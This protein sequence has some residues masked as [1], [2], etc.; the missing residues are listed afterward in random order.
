MTDLRPASRHWL[1]ASL[2]AAL[3]AGPVMG[4]ASAAPCPI[5]LP[6]AGEFS[7]GFGHRGGRL[8]PGVD[9]RAPVGSEVRAAAGGMVIFAG[10]YF[11]YG[12]MLEIEHRDGSV[13]R[14]AHL[15]RI[16]PDI[17]PGAVVLPGE[18]VA[19]LGRTGRTTGPHLH[20][21]LRRHGRAV[22]PWPWLTRTACLADTEVAEAPR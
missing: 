4:S 3:V 5:A 21:E 12:I 2:C 20:I 8:H 14:Y 15:A 7:S 6:V 22:D 13:A 11:A 16:N 10:R 17:R 19:T 1:T 18:P 9:I